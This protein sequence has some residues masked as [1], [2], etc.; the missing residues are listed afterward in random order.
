MSHGRSKVTSKHRWLKARLARSEVFDP[1]EVTICHFFICTTRRFFLM[2]DDQISGNKGERDSQRDLPLCF[3]R[4]SFQETSA[5][6]ERIR[7]ILNAS[8]VWPQATIAA[9]FR[10]TAVSRLRQVIAHEP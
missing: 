4:A 9:H 7:P 2:G 3:L 1:D 8:G 10:R 5:T 6:I